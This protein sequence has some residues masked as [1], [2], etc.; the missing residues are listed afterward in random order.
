MKRYS[1][2][3]FSL[4]FTVSLLLSA[5]SFAQKSS[6]LTKKLSKAE[7]DI[8]ALLKYT[9]CP[10]VAV[11]VVHKNELVYAKG[12]GY[13]D[14]ENK[15]PVTPNTLFAI[16]SSSKAFTGALLGQL[17]EK[18]LVDLDAPARTYLP[19]LKFFND[20][21]DRMVTVRDMLSHRTGLSRH[22]LSWYYFPTD[23]RDSLLARVQYHEPT[24]ALREG[25]QYNNFMYAAAGRIS[26][27]LMETSWEE[28][29]RQ[30]LFAPLEMKRSNVSIT[31]LEKA[32][33][34]ALGYSVDSDNNLEKEEYYPITG[35]AP[36]GSINSNV[37]DMANWLKVWINNG[38][39]NGQQVI[40]EQYVNEA[41][42]SQMVSSSRLPGKEHPDL[43]LNNYG[44]GWF[45]SSYR[46]HYRVEH[47]GNIDGFSA[48][49]AFYPSDSIGIVVL[50]NQDGSRVPSLTR[51]L[52]A[53]IALGI[54]SGDWLKSVK[55]QYEKENDKE[56]DA[57][58]AEAVSNMVEGTS[59][60]HPLSDYTGK[61]AHPGYGVIRVTAENGELHGQL[62]DKKF[63]LKHK[64]YD[65]FETLEQ[66]ASGIDSSA[67]GRFNLNFRTDIHGNI[68]ELTIALEGGL[69]P[70]V[71]SR[72]TE[73]ID[74]S[75]EDLEQYAGDFDLGGAM[76]NVSVKEGILRLLVPGQPEYTLIF[77]GKHQFAVK[78]L[79]GYSLEFVEEESTITALI[80]KQPNGTVKV[81]KKK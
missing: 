75:A 74:I 39:Y 42:V 22:D 15:K 64:H 63:W 31:E 13:R 21:L 24:L 11:A 20:D 37:T 46:G 73:E 25:F 5:P 49:V 50:S 18:E 32:D 6:P 67:A 3:L 48:N 51:N 7:A 16:G 53:D 81:P 1:S 34:A 14:Y 68:E 9:H 41:I 78:D 35:M 23:S 19:E 28:N 57:V 38:Q 69:D 10:G 80:M 29:I 8:E 17:E 56:T 72:Q 45:L 62:P 61:F 54:K 44:F 77:S 52:L 65:V 27:K 26:G 60:A 55:E 40:P 4:F 71:F 79:D 30:Q 33:E 47:G 76:V 43:H 36:A 70:M 66:K 58:S 12:F 59:P 2:T